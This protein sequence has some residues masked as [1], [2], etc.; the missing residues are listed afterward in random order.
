VSGTDQFAGRLFHAILGAQQVQAVYL[1]DCLGYYRALASSSDMTSAEL[2]TATG[3]AERYARE[4]LEHQA[5]CG[6]LTVIDTTVP[7]DRRRFVLPPEHAEVLIDRNSLSYL[8]PLARLMVAFGK[9]ID[10][11]TDAYRSGRGVRWADFGTNARQAQA[12]ANRP[13]FLGPLAKSYLPSL[14]EVDDVLNRGG[15]VAELGCGGGWA[16]IGIATGYPTAT[17]DAFDIDLP[18]IELAL[19]NARTAGVTDR[20]T[21]HYVADATVAL[22]EAQQ[23]GAYDL[24]CAFECVHDVPD[25]VSFLTTMRKMCA[26]TGFV[27]VMDGRTA[28]EFTAPGDEVEQIMY[29]YSITCCLPD[30]LAHQPSAATG[31]VMRPAVLDRYARDAGFRGAEILPI[32]NDFFRFY[33]LILPDSTFPDS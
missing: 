2:A 9:R 5:V 30:G 33:R 27:L 25:P 11:L 22:A 7:P 15:R 10:A 8:A 19:A 20:V 28:T 32:Q 16:A 6:Y 23:T 12:D 13:L 3:T 29:G 1:G 14:K 24:V 21:F 18:S 17:I 4:W 31:T 26:P